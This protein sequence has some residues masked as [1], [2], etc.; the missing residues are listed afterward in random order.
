MKHGWVNACI[1]RMLL[2]YLIGNISPIKKDKGVIIFLWSTVFIKPPHSLYAYD[3]WFSEM[4]GKKLNE[5]SRWAANI[6]DFTL[7]NKWLN[8]LKLHVN[9]RIHGMGVC[10]IVP[11]F[12][13]ISVIIEKSIRKK[14][15]DQITSIIRV[16]YLLGGEMC[17]CPPC[18]IGFP[19]LVCF[20]NTI[21]YFKRPQCGIGIF[22]HWNQ[23]HWMMGKSKLSK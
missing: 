21:Y 23:L 8:V 18:A 14:L 3:I 9:N 4:L 7:Y 20:Y 19:L 5:W 16:V 22:C 11:C 15:A 6:N 12:R 13:D 10:L 2:K 17:I 1:D